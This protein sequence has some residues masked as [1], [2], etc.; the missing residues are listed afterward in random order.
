M[1]EVKNVNRDIVNIQRAKQLLLYKNL[2][3]GNLG[4]SD[5]DAIFEW[6]RKYL[7]LV[8]CK[9]GDKKID[10][11]QN[12]LIKALVDRWVE[13]GNL[14][15]KILKLVTKFVPTELAIKWMESPMK[16]DSY[17]VKVSHNIPASEDVILA[18]TIVEA[19]Y[20]PSTK[21]WEKVPERPRFE[22][23]FN[24]L[25]GPSNWDIT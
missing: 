24:E 21:T 2:G 14:R 23:W 16:L 6:H 20:H 8:E 15:K 18:D 12:K 17:G 9:V 5:I 19:V 25:C 4:F 13:P 3:K 22:D 11:G 1:I 10:K 7:L